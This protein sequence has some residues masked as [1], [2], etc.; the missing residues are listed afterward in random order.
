[1]SFQTARGLLVLVKYRLRGPA[2]AKTSPGLLQAL[3]RHF[4]TLARTPTSHGLAIWQKWSNIQE[5]EDIKAH[6]DDRQRWEQWSVDRKKRWETFTDMELEDN[7]IRLQLSKFVEFLQQNSGQLHTM[8]L[9]DVLKT[10]LSSD[11]SS[12]AK[13]KVDNTYSLLATQIHHSLHDADSIL[14]FAHLPASFTLQSFKDLSNRWLDGCLI[15]AGSVMSLFNTMIPKLRAKNNISMLPKNVKNVIIVGDLHGD[16][17]SLTHIITTFGLPNQ[18]TAYV[19]N[20]DFVDRGYF[21]IEVLCSLL[22][23]LRQF[24]DR[25]FLNRGNHEDSFM[26]RAYGYYDELCLK[27]GSFKGQEIHEQSCKIFSVLPLCCLIPDYSTFVSHAGPPCHSD[28]SPSTST[29]IGRIRRYLRK[30][31]VASKDA[32][33]MDCLAATDGSPAAVENEMASSWL[34]EHMMWSDPLDSKNRSQGGGIQQTSGRGAG[35]LFGLDVVENFLNMHQLKNFVRS[36]QCV[37]DGYQLVAMDKG[38]MYTV[39]S[40]ADYMK[41]GNNG[42]VLKI[43]AAG[44]E[45]YVFYPEDVPRLT[46]KPASKKLRQHMEHLESLTDAAAVSAIFRAIDT[47]GDGVLTQEEVRQGMKWMKHFGLPDLQHQAEEIFVSRKKGKGMSITEFT[48]AFMVTSN[49]TL[50]SSHAHPKTTQ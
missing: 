27:Y 41:S 34:M 13:N 39:F 26:G 10:Q 12:A 14:P 44:V 24:P 38:N 23:L 31:T 21:S 11:Y 4:T 42:A 30:R 49:S 36:H 5:E 15:P 50:F 28:G 6:S 47:N 43:T 1:M 33:K 3:S 25:V 48:K 18:D 17:A 20:G 19:F 16:L 2:L 8:E 9:D 46:D 45:P 22:L 7:R 29:E 35:A 37:P 40:C 32:S